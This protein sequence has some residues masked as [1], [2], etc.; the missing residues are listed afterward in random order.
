[1]ESS[2]P[3]L[4]MSFDKLDSAD[5]VSTLAPLAAEKGHLATAP[6]GSFP[7]FSKPIPTVA[8]GGKCH[9]PTRGLEKGPGVLRVT[10]WVCGAAD[11]HPGE[12]GSKPHSAH[13]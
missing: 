4:P 13:C 6:T 3:S 2:T 11:V 9:H 10:Q 12:F 8:L 5:P 7:A 1:M